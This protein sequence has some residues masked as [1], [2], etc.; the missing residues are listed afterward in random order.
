MTFVLERETYS[1]PNDKSKPTRILFLVAICIPRSRNAGRIAQ[2]KSVKTVMEVDMYPSIT[3]K[4][5]GAQDAWPVLTRLVSQFAAIGRHRSRR[6]AKVMSHAATVM[7]S[8]V[9]TQKRKYRILCAIRSSV[10]QMELL[11]MPKVHVYTNNQISCH[12]RESFCIW[13]LSSSSNVPRP[14]RAPSQARP[15]PMMYKIYGSRV[16]TR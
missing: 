6:P 9:Y 3:M 16:S 5:F 7:T 10:T 12:I 4:P 13:S 8:S 2:D 14:A 1:D 15:I 11:T